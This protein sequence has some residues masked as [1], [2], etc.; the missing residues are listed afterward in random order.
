MTDLFIDIIDKN[1]PSLL[2]ETPRNHR[3]RGSHLSYRYEDANAIKEYLENRNVL[4]DVRHSVILRFAIAP[5]F[6]RYVDIW[7][8]VQ[9]LCEAV[10]IHQLEKTRPKL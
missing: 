5:L 3:D 9:M 4:C 2:L 8:A 7:D 6:L 10:N 1:C